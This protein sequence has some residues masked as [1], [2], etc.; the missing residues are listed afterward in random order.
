[1]ITSDS[2]LWSKIVI[3][4]FLLLILVL[5]L[6]QINSYSYRAIACH[7]DSNIVQV[8]N[9]DDEGNLEIIDT[10]PTANNVEKIIM[11]PEGKFAYI[12]YGWE[13]E[14]LNIDKYQNIEYGG[15]ALE[16]RA[17]SFASLS[18]NTKY[19]IYRW[20]EIRLFKINND[21]TLIDTGSFIPFNYD[22][23]P[24]E[25]H[26]ALREYVESKYNNTIIGNNWQIEQLCI[27][28]RTEDEEL[29]DTGQKIST[30]PY[31][32]NGS[33]IITPD[34]KYCYISG[35]SGLGGVGGTV[36]CEISPDGEVIY[37][38]LATDLCQSDHLRI[39]RDGRFFV[40]LANGIRD[41]RIEEDGSLTFIN[42]ITGLNLSQAFDVTPDNKYIVVSWNYNSYGQTVSV[43]RMYPDGTLEKLDKDQVWPGGF[44]DIRFIPPYVTSVDD[45]WEC[46]K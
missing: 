1:M 19:F 37:K 6:V 32:A 23:D 5:L 44:S 43:I 42:S 13:V 25:E 33:V 41:Y 24:P 36:Y 35:N 17:I 11:S 12:Y 22:L 14:F 2:F 46:Y 15:K 26:F 29:I 4:K 34:G 40:H 16:N 7:F 28:N 10:I 18:S 39:T 3:K 38:G 21:L 20:G 9:L 45:V 27:L 31:G 8:L 30:E